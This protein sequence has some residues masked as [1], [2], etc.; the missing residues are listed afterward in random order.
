MLSFLSFF[1][2]SSRVCLASLE[3][4]LEQ[5]STRVPQELPWRT[6][7]DPSSSWPAQGRLELRGA[8]LRYR[9]GLPPAI[10]QL[11]FEVPPAT[12]LGIVGRSGAGKSSLVVLLLRLVELSD[13]AVLIDGVD[14]AKVGLHTLR[15]A[16]ALVPQDPFLVEG[17]LRKN[18]D[19][20]EWHSEAVLVKA[21]SCVGLNLPL[22]TE[23]GKGGGQLSAGQR[24][25][26]AMAR[27]T[28][29]HA[30]IVLLDEPTANCDPRTDTLLQEVTGR[31]FSGRTVLCIA[32]RLNTILSYDA[33]LVMEAGR[34]I[35]HGPTSRLAADSSSRFAQMVSA[36]SR[37]GVSA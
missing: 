4:L 23:V 6:T 30:R 24:Q 22:D 28:L 7:D 18:M 14:T 31:A 21:L 3:R 9:P 13:G 2:S 27:A 20:F 37:S 16:M 8:T 15:Q 32:H 12:S 26:V 25:L 35:E 34:G 11:T 5:K 17:S 33:V 29:S 10:D 19:P 36:S 1:T